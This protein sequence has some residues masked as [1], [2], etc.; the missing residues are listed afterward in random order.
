MS[1][2]HPSNPS[3]CGGE[4]LKGSPLS[5]GVGSV[6]G[7]GVGIGSSGSRVGSGTG[8][9]EGFGVGLGV[10]VGLGASVTSAACERSGP[11]GFAG[12]GMGNEG[13]GTVGTRVGTSVGIGAGVGVGVGVGGVGGVG[14]ALPQAIVS[15]STIATALSNHFMFD[16]QERWE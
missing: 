6:S 13:E 3:G 1:D 16:P 4:G 15:S 2:R 7:A 5:T 14:V 12:E 11:A 8:V 9:S 10:S